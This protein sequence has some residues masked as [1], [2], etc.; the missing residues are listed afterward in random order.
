MPFD[1][2]SWYSHATSTTPVPMDASQMSSN[3]SKTETVEQENDSYQYEQDQECDGDELFAVKGKGK[4]GFKGNC[5]NCGIGGHKVDRCWQ[6]GKGKGF[7]GDCGNGKVDPKERDD[8]REI[9]Q[10]LATRG[11]FL[12]TIPIGTVKRVVLRS[13]RGRVSNLFLFSVQSA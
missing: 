11:S 13:I 3:V 4:G 2:E 6:R 5:F 9:G 1:K 8:A 10:I 7:K 12:G